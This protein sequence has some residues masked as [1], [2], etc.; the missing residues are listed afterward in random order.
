MDEYITWFVC[1][2]P[3]CVS[4]SDNAQIATCVTNNATLLVLNATIYY[5]SD[6][7]GYKYKLLIYFIT[8]VYS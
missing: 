7:L 6:L 4:I 5:Y 3:A 1:M 8:Y 2:M